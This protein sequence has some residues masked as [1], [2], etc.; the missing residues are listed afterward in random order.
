[1]TQKL[2]INL[3]ESWGEFWTK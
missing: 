1:M 3:D 2:P